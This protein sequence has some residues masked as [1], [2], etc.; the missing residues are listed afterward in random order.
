LQR[1]RP[2]VVGNRDRNFA[3]NFRRWFHLLEPAPDVD[4]SRP[5]NIELQTELAQVL[6]KIH[7]AGRRR[8]SHRRLKPLSVKNLL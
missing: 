3:A 4:S 7:G 1:Y 8:A 6:H 2:G 5:H